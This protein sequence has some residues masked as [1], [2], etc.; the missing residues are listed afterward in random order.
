[1]LLH[2]KKWPLGAAFLTLTA[3]AISANAI[4]PLVTTLAHQTATPYAQ[5]GYLFMLQYLCFTLASLC[6]GRATRA[7][8]SSRKL[9]IIGLLGLAALFALGACL[10]RFIWFALW[11]LPVGFF[12]GLIETFA[13]VIIAGHKKSNSSKLLNLSQVF[14]CLGAILAPQLIA[15][16]LGYQ[17][18]WRVIFILLSLSIFLIGL[19]FILLSRNSKIPDTKIP[20]IIADSLNSKPPVSLWSDTSFYLLAAVLFLYVIIEMSSVCWM[21]AYFEKR[22]ELTASSAAWRLA[23]FWLGVIIGRLLILTLPDAWT[24][25]PALIVGA[26]GMIAA[27]AGL[28]FITSPLTATVIV[29]LYGIAAGPI[30]PVIVMISQK[31]RHCPQFTS[32]VIG[33]GAAGAGIGPLLG[34]P[35]IKYFGL[36]LFF[37]LLT[38]GS[39]VLLAVIVCCNRK[40][41]WGHLDKTSNNLT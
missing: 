37:P 20:T 40:L 9:V 8:I 10:S 25:W 22:F 18:S 33:F 11:I 15:I 38:G 35:I 7:G 29:V 13:T 17:I 30:W 23:M 41:K 31:I 3:F 32:A 5:F 24:F 2:D 16:L 27:N 21:A 28:T 26:I 1:M 14:Y 12:G 34:S 6:G 36:N 39:I 19:F 4:P